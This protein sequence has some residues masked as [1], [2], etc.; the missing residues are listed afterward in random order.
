MVLLRK[1]R[2]LLRRPLKGCYYV[3]RLIGRPASNSIRLP[4]LQITQFKGTVANQ[5]RDQT[6]IE[7]MLV[8]ANLS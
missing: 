5:I 3:G 1:I 2:G 6:E 7:T 8:C 4:K